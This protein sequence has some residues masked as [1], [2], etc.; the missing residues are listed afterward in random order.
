MEGLRLRRRQG[1]LADAGP[2]HRLPGGPAQ[3]G[4]VHHAPQDAAGDQRRVRDDE[5]GGLH[6][7]RRGHEVGYPV[8][9]H[10]NEKK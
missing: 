3:D 4:R 1:P 5:T 9:A 10:L 6:P 7:L 2:H 8:F